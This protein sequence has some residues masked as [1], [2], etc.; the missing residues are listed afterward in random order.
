MDLRAEV[1][2]QVKCL[3]EGIGGRIAALS[4]DVTLTNRLTPLPR[5]CVS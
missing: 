5:T 3:A 4:Q 1:E 2:E